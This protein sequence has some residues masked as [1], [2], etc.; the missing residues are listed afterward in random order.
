MFYILREQEPNP[1]D[2]K[3]LSK[4]GKID[5]GMLSQVFDHNVNKIVTFTNSTHLQTAQLILSKMTSTDVTLEQYESL[6]SFFNKYDEFDDTFLMI[7]NWK[8]IPI[9]V[10]YLLKK[11][12]IKKREDLKW[13]R[14]NYRGCVVIDDDERTW[15]F[16]QDAIH[17]GP[18]INARG[19]DDAR[20]EPSEK[21]SQDDDDDSEEEEES[22]EEESEE[23]DSQDDDEDSQEEEEEE[24]KEEEKKELNI[25]K[26]QNRT[27]GRKE[28]NKRKLNV[29]FKKRE[30]V[31]KE[32]TKLNQR[33]PKEK[34]VSKTQH[35][36]GRPRLPK[37]TSDD[38]E[39]ERCCIQ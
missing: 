21:D 39:E 17:N 22:E 11:F 2:T 18:E 31:E 29:S 9:L 38:D 23:E 26:K 7:W 35:G 25:E 30:V 10:T 15:T 1:N 14:L 34:E 16:Y 4:K 6:D 27:K 20:T 37:T 33:K 5:C 8:E 12:K 24:K 3:V 19:F 28:T 13:N 36:R 32:K